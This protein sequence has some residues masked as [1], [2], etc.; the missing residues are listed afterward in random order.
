MNPGTTVH[1]VIYDPVNPSDAFGRKMLENLTE[2]S[3]HMPGLT[4][5]KTLA[6]HV[7]RL[8]EVGVPNAHAWTMRDCWNRIPTELKQWTQQLEM[9]DE[10]EEWNLL[11]DHYAFIQGWRGKAPIEVKIQAGSASITI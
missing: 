5:F 4:Q 3:I 10:E 7:K 8:H 11:A 1:L 2:R 9:V 6:D